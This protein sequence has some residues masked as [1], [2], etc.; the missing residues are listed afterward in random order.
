[1][2]RGLKKAPY[3]SFDCLKR[4]Y[5]KGGRVTI[6]SDS[7]SFE[8]VAFGFNETENIL[9]HIGFKETYIYDGC[10]FIPQPLNIN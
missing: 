10:G 2:S 1:M 4:I 9:K 5:E 3:P 8:T 7:H 6:S